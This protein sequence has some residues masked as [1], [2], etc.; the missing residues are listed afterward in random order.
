MFRIRNVL[1]N[2]RGYSNCSCLLIVF[3][4]IGAG[5]IGL[6]I[7]FL[8]LKIL[9]LGILCVVFV[10]VWNAYILFLLRERDTKSVD[11]WRLALLGL[12]GLLG[13]L[14]LLGMLALGAADAAGINTEVVRQLFFSLQL[15]YLQ[16]LYQ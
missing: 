4:L 12:L 8:K 14:A 3:C 1:K 15:L 6:S 9:W 13:L 10:I 11:A 5:F 2:Q 16:L 7:S